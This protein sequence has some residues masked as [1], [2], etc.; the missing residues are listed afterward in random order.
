MRPTVPP[1]RAAGP[2]P[3]PPA[4][5]HTPRSRSGG[6][7]WRYAPHLAAGALNYCPAR[8]GGRSAIRRSTAPDDRPATGHCRS[9]HARNED[10]S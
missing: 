7:E 2:T 10:L 5:D 3:A 4:P 8:S 9:C 1:E 6:K